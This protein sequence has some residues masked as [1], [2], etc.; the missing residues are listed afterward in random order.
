ML[1]ELGSFE[2][3]DSGSSFSCLAEKQL[4]A[5]LAAPQKLAQQLD[6]QNDFAF[7]ARLCWLSLRFK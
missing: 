7:M 6:E 4:T 1:I 2:R 5:L 3:E